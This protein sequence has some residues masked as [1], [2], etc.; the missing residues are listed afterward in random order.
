MS[1]C[2]ENVYGDVIEA[3]VMISC[4]ASVVTVYSAV[5]AR[6][7]LTK[8]PLILLPLTTNIHFFIVYTYWNRVYIELLFSY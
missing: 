7:S 5:Y 3:E 4:V 1:E 6:L 2:G 8:S